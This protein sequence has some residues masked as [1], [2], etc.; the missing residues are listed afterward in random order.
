MEIVYIALAV[1]VGALVKSITGMGLPPIV[2]P[3]LALF[4]PPQDAIIIV[5]LTSVTTNTYLAWAY[6]D[7][8]GDAK[9]L[10]PMI[11]T[12]IIG[13]PLGV[14]FLTNLDDRYVGLVLGVAVIIYLGVSLWKPGWRLSEDAARRTAVP[15]GL[16]GGI[17][18]GATGL[19]SPVLASYIHA[20]GI[21]PRAFVFMISTLFQVFALAQLIGFWVAGVYT[22]QLV[23]ASVVAAVGATLVLALGT[24]VSPR[25]SPVVFHRLVMGVLAA[26]AIKMLWDVFN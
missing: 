2:I 25:V 8:A 11:V 24:H 7:A 9:H 23:T 17:M 10:V 21:P 15:A 13:A 20:L 18:Q 3:V 26:S 12:G 6:R 5:T 19:S 4:V 16:A 1:V 22:P 14:L